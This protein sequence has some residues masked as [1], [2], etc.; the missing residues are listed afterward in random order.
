LVLVILVAAAGLLAAA[1]IQA[2][3][4]I[5]MRE[6]A[7]STAYGKGITA[8]LAVGL[9][10]SVYGIS[11]AELR[12]NARL[13][14]VAVTLGVAGKAFL[15]GGIMVLAYGS[16]GFLLLGVA[17]AQI[18]PLSVAASISDY[19]MSQRAKSLLL[20]WACFDDPITIL[21]VAYLAPIT[22]PAIARQGGTALAIA[23]AGSYAGQIALNGTLVAIGGL[24]WY[25]VAVRGGLR[26]GRRATVLLCLILA[27]LIALAAAF[28]LLIGIAVSGLFFRPQIER[29]LSGVVSLAF[30]AATFLLGLLLVSGADL[31]AGLLLGVTVFVMQVLAGALIGRGLPRG[32]RGRLALGQQNGLTAIALALALAPYLPAAVGIVAVAVL[33]VNTMHILA[34]GIW[35]SAVRRP[36]RKEIESLVLAK[37]GVPQLKVGVA[38]VPQEEADDPS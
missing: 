13:V 38:A 5:R 34:N 17:V 9:F 20:A 26:E 1:A 7:N 36:R 11:L 4:G 24:A 18:D 19:S 29:L 16:A 32:D 6:I 25:L 3:T 31:A 2:S 35:T 23:G 30:Y 27:A 21:L 15:T 10:A 12:R 22:L 37:N 33:T 28:G 14:L 8:L